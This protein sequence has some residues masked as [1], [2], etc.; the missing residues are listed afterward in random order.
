MRPRGVQ[1]DNMLQRRTLPNSHSLDTSTMNRIGDIGSTT[2]RRKSLKDIVQYVHWS[3]R[4][5]SLLT[6]LRHFTPAWFAVTM[7][8]SKYTY[9]CVVLTI[10]VGTGSIAILFHNFPYAGDSPVMRGFAL[11]FFFFNLVLFL[12]FSVITAARYIFFPGIWFH[13][14]RHPVQSLYIGTFPMGATTLI[15][16]ASSDIFQTYGFGGKPF[17]YT[18]WACWWINVAISMAC[19]FGMMHVM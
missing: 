16:V 13:M 10:F 12:L 7:G 5:K 19:C 1:S 3:T 2:L 18:V 15:N 14:I 4:A 9:L 6:I 8:E 17:I 11:G